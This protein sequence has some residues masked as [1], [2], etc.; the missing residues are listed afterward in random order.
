MPFIKKKSYLAKKKGINQKTCGV[1]P[2]RLD[3]GLTLV[4]KEPEEFEVVK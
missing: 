1:K 2:H 3:P 4:V